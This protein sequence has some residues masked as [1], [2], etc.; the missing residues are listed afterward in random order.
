MTLLQRVYILGTLCDLLYKTHFES[1]HFLNLIHSNKNENKI[2]D[3]TTVKRDKQEKW[4][5]PKTEYER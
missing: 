5:S 4:D 1:K 3:T 2:T